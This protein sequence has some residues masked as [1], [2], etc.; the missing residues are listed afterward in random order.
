MPKSN[1]QEKKVPQ[2]LASATKWG[3]NGE[4]RAALLR[5]KGRTA[6][7]QRRANWQWA[8]P[9]PGRGHSS[10]SWLPELLRWGRHKTQAQ[11]SLRFCGGPENWNRMQLRARSLESNLEPEQCRRESTHAMSEGKPSV[12]GTLRVLPTHSY[13]CLQ[14]PSLPA[15]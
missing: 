5:N 9:D 10:S 4:E 11:P 3:L 13:I 2:M 8:S 12:A 6:Q 1:S 7:F 15:A 14:H